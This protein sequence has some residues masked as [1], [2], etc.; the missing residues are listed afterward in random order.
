MNE[1][2]IVPWRA[3]HFELTVSGERNSISL[4]GAQFRLME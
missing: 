1:P 2:P 4:I 3:R